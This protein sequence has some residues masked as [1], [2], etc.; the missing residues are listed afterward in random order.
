[1]KKEE[2][3]GIRSDCKKSNS[4]P[5]RGSVN[6]WHQRSFL[7]EFLVHKIVAVLTRGWNWSSTNA[8]NRTALRFPLP[9]LTYFIFLG[10][11]SLQNDVA[12]TI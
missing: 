1:M 11:F 5:Q 12:P 6:T 10:W 7:I 4:D 2:G 9:D 8:E 3:H